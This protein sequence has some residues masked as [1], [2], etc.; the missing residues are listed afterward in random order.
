M[1]TIQKWHDGSEDPDE[2]DISDCIV[3]DGVNAAFM[4]VYKMR[5]K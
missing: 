4:D 2:S 5:L 3:E 1:D